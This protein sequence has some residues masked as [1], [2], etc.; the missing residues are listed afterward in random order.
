MLFFKTLCSEKSTTTRVKSH[1]GSDGKTL[2]AIQS[3]FNSTSSVSL[4]ILIPNV[5]RV[6]GLASNTFLCNSPKVHW[7]AG[8]DGFDFS[9]QRYCN[10]SL[11]RLKSSGGSLA[12]T[13]RL[14]TGEVLKA[15]RH[16]RNA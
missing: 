7:D 8:C 5:G 4:S 1:G 11:W 12:S 6:C 3:M 13:W 2:P 9:L 14:S 10:D 15:P 16:I